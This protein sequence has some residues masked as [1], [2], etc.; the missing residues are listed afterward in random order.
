MQSRNCVEINEILQNFSEWTVRS[1]FQIVAG[2]FYAVTFALGLFS[3]VFIIVAMLKFKTLLSD[4]HNEFIGNLAVADL[5][6][7]TVTLPITV[8]VDFYKEWPF[9]PIACRI[10][11]FVQGLSVLVSSF[12]LSVIAIDRY[13]RIV[14]REQFSC[15]T[16]IRLVFVIWVV[17]GFI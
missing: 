5:L 12:T 9:G 6:I 3:N 13:L 14:K 1:E 2:T 11:P 16:S 7:C 10:V 15:R 17:S 4:F 8:Y